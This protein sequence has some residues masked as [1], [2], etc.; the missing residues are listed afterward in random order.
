MSPAGDELRARV[1]AQLESLAGPDGELATNSPRATVAAAVNYHRGRPTPDRE[2]FRAEVK[3]A[4]L[5][6]QRSVRREG[7]AALLTAGPP[8]AGKSS[9]LDQLGLTDDGWRRLDADVVKDFIVDDAARSG[10]YDDVLAYRLADGHPVM[11]AELASLAHV[12]SLSLLDEIR[13]ECLA[14]GENVVIEGTLIWPPAGG[15][16]LDELLDRGYQDVTVVD[17]EVSAKTAHERATQRWWDGRQ[18]RIDTGAGLGG[19]FTPAG[20]IDR[21]YEGGG[22]RSVCAA[23][24]RALFDSPAARDVSTMR[25]RVLDS[26]DSRGTVEE[27]YERLSGVLQAHSRPIQATLDGSPAPLSAAQLAAQSFARPP[28]RVRPASSARPGYGP[29]PPAPAAR[30]APVATSSRNGVPAQH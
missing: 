29:G 27:R 30:R 17:V 28:G 6:R 21:A 22:L 20:A 25:L 12:E 14:R 2:A 19:R 11:P 24:A 5:D 10:R 9:A 16:L 8:G 23:N 7:K 15:L 26:T 4:F 3:A 13:G 1:A 18:E